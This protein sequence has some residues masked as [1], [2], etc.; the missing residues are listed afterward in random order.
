M[1]SKAL[2]IEDLQCWRYILSDKKIEV[3]MKRF[4]SV[5]KKWQLRKPHVSYRRRTD[6]KKREICLKVCWFL[7]H[8]VGTSRVKAL[9]C[10]SASSGGLI[11]HDED[12][13]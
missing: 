2:L 1:F 13:G 8:Y 6:D 10:L 9:V 5:R 7:E 4:Y 12:K 11:F 3:H